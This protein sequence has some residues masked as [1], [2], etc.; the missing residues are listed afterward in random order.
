MTKNKPSPEEFMEKHKEIMDNL[1][2]MGMEQ[3]CKHFG[4][5]IEDGRALCTEY[6]DNEL[7]HDITINLSRDRTQEDF[8]F[9][10]EINKK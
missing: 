9:S 2:T 4:L 10:L 8:Q 6:C 3:T 1:F 7:L 5:S